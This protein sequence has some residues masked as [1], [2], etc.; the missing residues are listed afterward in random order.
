MPRFVIV[1]PVLNGAEF[2]PAT[3]DSVRAQTDGD[4]VHYLVDGGSTDG[5]LD[6]LAQAAEEDPRRRIVTGEDR[7]LFDAWFK[8]FERAYADGITDPETICGW[9]G[10]DDLIMPWAFA[11]LRQYFDQPGVEWVSALPCIWDA[12]GRLNIV[13][14]FNW[15]P[16]RLIRAGLFNN[17]S[18]GSLQMESIFFTRRLLSRLS[19][20]VL[21]SIRTKKLAGDFQLWREFARHAELVPVMTAVAGFRLHGANL[22]SVQ[23]DAYLR[24]VKEAGGRLP[25]APVGR[26][27]RVSFRLLTLIKT[28]KR[29]RQAWRQGAEPPQS[30]LER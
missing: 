5:T 4:W 28:E 23:K 29:F 15:C 17:R 22:S 6:I 13:Q 1:T 7:G 16:R 2:I 8:G 30:R 9:L 11:T 19:P 3:L 14:P 21:E 25:P 24:E 27:L 10:S 18:I 20:D 12:E 26:V